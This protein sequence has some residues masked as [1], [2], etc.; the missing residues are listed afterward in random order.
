MQTATAPTAAPVRH[1][2]VLDQADLDSLLATCRRALDRARATQRTVLA[3]W[4]RPLTVTDPLAIWSR[5]RRSTPRSFLWQSAWDRGSVVAIGTARDL[6]GRGETRM[7]SVRETWAELSRNPVTGGTTA[8]TPLPGADGPL[9]IGG[10]AFSPDSTPETRRLPDALLW[11]PSLQLRSALPEPGV[12]DR[13]H[14]AELRLNAVLMHDSD[15][16]Q[17][18]ESLAQLADRCLR[19]AGPPRRQPSAPAAR[20]HTSVELPGADDWKGLVRRATGRIRDGVF[21]KLVLARELRVTA[22]TP[23][24]VPATVGRLREANP[25]TT[26]FAVDH[27]EYTFLGATPEY[28]VRVDDRTVHALGLAG[29]APRGATPE[30]DE[31]LERELVASP[32]IQHE[33]DV[34]VQMLRN[35]FHDSCADVEIQTPPRVVKLTNVQHLSTDVRGRLAPGSEAGV[36]DFVELLHPTP[37]LGGHPRQESLSWLSDNEGFDRGWY[38]GVVGWAAPAGEGQFAV[39]IRSALL[40]GSS[41]S[42]FAGCGLVAD[43]DPEAEYAETCAKLRPMMSALGIE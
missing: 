22:S 41:A 38:A 18:A 34:V 30:E 7:A 31:A 17:L 14:P 27:E 2:S 13:A 39:A 25:G 43:S 42:L 26:V 23:F 19:T 8:T 11:V 6:R 20:T 32:K 15:P 3:S 16:E 12:A 5:A 9:A 29:T 10:F 28:L 21:E 40:D 1:P 4:A 36:L 24:D 37:A 33:H 35:A